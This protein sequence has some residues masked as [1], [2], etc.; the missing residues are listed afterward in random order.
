VR[1][2]LETDE[3]P[4]DD[5]KTRITTALLA[6]I[7]LAGAAGCGLDGYK[8]S[9]GNADAP[10]A[11]TEKDGWTV[12]AS[13]DHFPNIAFRCM[14]ANGLYNPKTSENDGARQLVV[15]ANDP[16]CKGGAK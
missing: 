9:Q 16:Q 3:I 5:M 7:A 2:D 6:I 15:V 8:E 4:G 11:R 10:I 1:T 12:L 14:G 13:P